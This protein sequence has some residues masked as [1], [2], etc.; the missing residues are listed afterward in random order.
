M[1]NNHTTLT[2]LFTD[3]ADA[4]REKTGGTESIVADNFPAAIGE[5]ETCPE[6][7]LFLETKTSELGSGSW[8]SV[9]YGGGKF[10]AIR[11]K[12]NLYSYSENGFDWI[13]G[14]LSFQG[15]GAVEVN[16][17]D[18]KFIIKFAQNKDYLES[19]DGIT[20]TMRTFP[21]SSYVA[22]PMA[23][24]DNKLIILYGRD[25][26]YHNIMAYSTDG[27]VTWT[28]G[29]MPTDAYWSSVAYGSGKFVAVSHYY[30]NS[31]TATNIAA[32]SVDGINWTQ[33][34]M[35]TTALWIKIIYA[36]NM[37]I[38]TSQN[39][40]ISAYSYDG[41]NWMLSEMP[42]S[43]NWNVLTYGN[44]KFVA[45]GTNTAVN[46][47]AAIDIVAY[48]IDGINWVQSSMPQ[49]AS[50]RS[51]TYG[52]GKFVAVAQDLTTAA[53]SHDGI[54]WIFE[55][56][57]IIDVN[58]TDVTEETVQATGILDPELATQDDLITQLT[59]ALEGRIM[60][61]FKAI[62]FSIGEIYYPAEE[63]M[64]WLE[65]VES[66]YNTGGFTCYGDN[67]EVHATLTSIVTNV[68]I[69]GGL[70]LGSSIIEP[71]GKYKITTG[72]GDN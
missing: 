61:S 6:D 40:T 71:N 22:L 50:W 37:F 21:F 46:S 2:S 35:P 41:I 3:I 32:Y 24:G 64:T 49:S 18:N 72:G 36:N 47:T 42:V 45:M 4:I 7:A 60:P 25:T 67:Y 55:D 44:G 39:S 70:L 57:L 43:A 51:V 54:N 56:T 16:Y 23:Y 63:G 20:W 26:Y 48:S 14:N 38:A 15:Y 66:D 10:I 30:K 58:N 68:N 53:V 62:C 19:T 1:A 11:T 8:M 59:S 28:Q 17:Y 31:A 13:S 5:I 69:G 65:W 9:A 33:I 34:E 52:D 12:E 29:M 27:G